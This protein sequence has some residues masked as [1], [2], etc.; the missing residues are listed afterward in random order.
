MTVTQP[1]YA[2]LETLAR[3][4]VL[5]PEAGTPERADATSHTTNGDDHRLDSGRP[6]FTI[7]KTYFAH[8]Y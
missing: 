3:M 7:E 1:L 8:R 4:A 5:P 6:A 2:L